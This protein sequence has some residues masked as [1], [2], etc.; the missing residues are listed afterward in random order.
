MQDRNIYISTSA[1]VKMVAVVVAFI[2]LWLTKDIV[3]LFVISLFLAAVMQPTAEWAYKRKIPRGVTVLFLYFVLFG[4]FGLVITLMIPTLIEQAGRLASLLG[5]QWG[6]IQ[7]ISDSFK[8]FAG[9]YGFSI[10]INS[11]I[12]SIQTQLGGAAN[13]LVDLLSTVFGG[14]AAFIVVL[15]LSFYL[16]AQEDKAITLV[17]DWV[18]SKHRKFA[19]HLISQLQDKMSGW[20]RGQIIL[21]VIIGVFYF[22]GLS[23]LGVEGALVLSVFGGLVEFIPYLGPILAAGPILLVAFSHSTVTGLLA[24]ALMIVV[25][26]LENQLIVPKVMQKAVGLNPLVSILSLLVGAQLFGF[27]GALMAIPLGTAVVLV[28]KEVKAYRS[29]S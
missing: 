18:P 4:I 27:V 21:A 12:A 22:I 24:L 19:L 2:V 28:I 16:V 29:S 10:N 13:R 6:W 23:V 5:Q 20:L 8:D 11:G 3:T 25:Q 9:K 17:Q 14:V 15:V 1:I 26:Q 7:N